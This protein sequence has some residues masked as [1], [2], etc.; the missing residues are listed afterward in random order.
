MKRVIALIILG[1]IVAAGQTA[2]AALPAPDWPSRDGNAANGNYNAFETT[3]TAKNVLKLKV[4]WP[5]VAISD[6][7]YPVVAGNRLYVPFNARKTVHVRAIDIK[8]GRAL[9]TY[10]KGACGG[11]LVAN[12]DLYLAGHI[13]QVLDATSG[14][15]LA[16]VRPPPGTHG[17]AFVYPQWD[18][19]FILAGYDG[20]STSSVYVTDQKL[21]QVLRKLPSASAS[22]AILSGHV[23]TRTSAGSAFYDETNG[24]VLAHPSYLGSDWFAGT[25]LA[26][27]VSAF[28]HHK[29][30]LYAIGDTGKRVW[31]RV[32]GP[33]LATA[34]SDWPHAMSD[35]VLAV[36]TLQPG[37]GVLAL[38]PLTGHF[39]WKRKLAN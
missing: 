33:N 21:T 38:N 9:A 24:K 19:N 23:Y 35:S 32:V 22:E 18:Q 34:G 26:Y 25:Q 20:G 30:K 8:T 14:Q 13:L 16:Q 11:I 12:G 6:R 15:K 2:Q 28:K 5:P 39:M 7:S 1:C 36:K 3:L 17:C 10:N 29:T 27:T 37:Q 4:A 31:S